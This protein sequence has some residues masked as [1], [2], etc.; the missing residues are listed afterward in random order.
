MD[1]SVCLSRFVLGCCKWISHDSTGFLWLMI[2]CRV[3]INSMPMVACML[4]NCTL[5]Y[6]TFLDIHLVF[7]FPCLQ[8]SASFSNV[9][10]IATSTADGVKKHLT[11]TSCCGSFRCI[12]M[13]FISKPKFPNYNI[14]L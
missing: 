6:F 14:N 2:K 3:P 7:S 13:Q 12:Q 8:V 11:A 4:C 10:V 1:S 5:L 9:E